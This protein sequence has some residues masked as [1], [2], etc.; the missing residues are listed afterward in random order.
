LINSFPTRRPRIT[1]MAD[2]KVESF[3]LNILAD[4]VVSLLIK[5]NRLVSH[6]T[7]TYVGVPISQTSSK[8][9][10]GFGLVLFPPGKSSCSS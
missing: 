9:L 6:T 7:R 5:C 1:V 2:T 8:V 3:V 4:L 10:A